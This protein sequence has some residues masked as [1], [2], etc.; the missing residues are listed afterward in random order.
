[1]FQRTFGRRGAAA[2]V[3]HRHTG[4]RRGSNAIPNRAAIALVFW[5]LT[6][7]TLAGQR[8]D[9]ATVTGFVRD[10]TGAVLVGVTV[11]LTPVNGGSAIATTTDSGGRY[12]FGGLR[13]GTYRISVSPAGFAE[14][15][16]TVRFD[17]SVQITMD[18][19][20]KPAVVETVDVTS[21]TLTATAG[22]ATTTLA[23]TA[24]ASLPD[25]AG[26]LL[27]RLRELAGATDP[28]GQIDV[29]IDGSRQL[30]WLP[31]KQVIQAVRIS[32]NAMA[33]EFA[34]PGQPRVEI[35]TKPG[36]SRLH[37]D[38]SADFSNEALNSRNALAPQHPS[39]HLREV[40]GYLSGP[41]I[42]NHWSFTVYR[43]YWNQQLDKVINATVLGP[44]NV[45]TPFVETAPTASRVDSLWAE[46]TVQL[47][48][49]QTFAGSF[50]RTTTDARNLG[51]DSGL[52]LPQR[53][54]SRKTAETTL[55]G[56]LIST[57][58]DRAFNELR[59]HIGPR[60]S[61]MVADSGAPA[62]V[63]FDAFTA[64]GNQEALL[65]TT[66]HLEG[67]LTDLFTVSVR[68]HTLKFG[69]DARLT[70]RR[71]IDATSTGGT[72]V[73]GSDFERDAAGHPIVDSSGE[74]IVIAPIDR[75]RRTALGV[76]GYRPAQ[77]FM[78]RGNP[79][80]R[81][82]DDAVSAFAQDDWAPTARVS[83]NYGMRFD[84][85]SAASVPGF[86]VRLGGAAALDNSRK[87]IVRVGLGTF[88][89][90]IDPELTVETM[91]LDGHHQEQ[92]LI[93][94][95]SFFPDIPAN[96][97]AVPAALSRIY[98]KASDL[99]APRILM[100]LLGFERTIAPAVYVTVRYSFQ[101]GIGL[102][103]T[104]NINAPDAMGARPDPQLGQVLQYES[105]GKLRRHELSTG[106][107][108]NTKTGTLFAN[109]RYV[110]AWSDTDGRRT[111][112]ADGGRLDQEFGP[113][114]A[115]RAHSATAGAELMLPAG[116]LVSPY[117]TVASGHVFNLTTGFDNNGDGLFA[118]R[119]AVVAA[120]TPGA[121]ETAY[122][123]LLANR[124]SD[125]VMITRNAGR[126]PF[127][128]R[129]DL[130]VARAFR[131]SKAT[132]VLAANVENLL[133]RANFEGVN[134]VITSPSF[135][136]ANRAGLPRRVYA[137]AGF[138]F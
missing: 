63:V 64:G 101:S 94:Q 46:T 37:G 39:G 42:P 131:R 79:S 122:G 30:L 130:R 82:R 136:T 2:N 13:A 88:H 72:F 11:R 9:S 62:I 74:R 40:T 138:S 15:A 10:S 129:L 127:T 75:Y 84:W 24:L 6:V 135:G 3:S 52:D 83:L 36:G 26:G 49:G 92:V 57:P 119:P 23:G 53:S 106:W 108:W 98:V 59:V 78:M 48:S 80:L 18:L 43:G 102:T 51:L 58:T 133:N 21:D 89:Q 29:T 109:Y 8:A 104:R 100:S 105:T 103:R 114:A 19:V 137:A 73:F 95:P 115:D 86:G 25:D 99:R 35:I 54:Y 126:E 32:T 113:A 16:H 116:V 85:Q 44:G 61:L 60:S 50:S 47:G 68:N 110:R 76:T 111:V 5:M 121:I 81:F 33:A 125:A 38:L 67:G 91:R 77:F 128:G 134:G 120:G 97:D 45:P 112:A 93:D 70:T 12:Q 1:M 123:W 31:P 87:N 96:L 65:S 124:P 66:D 107:R 22:L 55:G 56:A 27:Q 41:I 17:G 20:L 28:L 14:A 34:E 118:D 132:L 69:L 7:G 90:R 4:S 117:L 71:S